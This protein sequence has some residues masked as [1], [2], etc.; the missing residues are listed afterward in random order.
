[1]IGVVIAL[2]TTVV[3]LTLVGTGRAGE[4]IDPVWVGLVLGVVDLAVLTV[5]LV[6]PRPPVPARPELG[7]IDHPASPSSADNAAARL[8]GESRAKAID[9]LGAD[10]AAVRIGALY[11]LER[12]AQDHPDQRQ[13]IV[14]ILCGY[15]RM[16]F[17]SGRESSDTP[18]LQVRVTAQRILAEHL[19]PFRLEDIMR[20]VGAPGDITD[21]GAAER[22]DLELTAEGEPTN[23]RYWPDLALDL[24]GAVLI[25]LDLYRCRVRSVTFSRA[26]FIGD[27]RF[28][29][30]RVQGPAQ[31]DAAVF[32]GPAR[33]D[34]AQFAASG[35]FRDTVFHGSARFDAARLANAIFERTRFEADASFAATQFIGSF[36]TFENSRF[37][38]PASFRSARFHSDTRFDGA[39]FERAVDLASAGFLGESSFTDTRVRPTREGGGIGLPA[40]LGVRAVEGDQ[41]WGVLYRSRPQPVGNALYPRQRE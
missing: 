10:S 29:K 25:D 9:Q 12:L 21:I 24:T 38:G 3:A 2:I 23:P 36:A 26:E 28:L 11:V 5:Y 7:P 6:V 40:E 41:Q 34:S 37:S 1:V 20:L 19:Q 35:L 8:I 4:G 27:T 17:A 18:E 14:N 13:T 33:F 22:R 30:C 16:P 31:F 39:R 15:L 32:S